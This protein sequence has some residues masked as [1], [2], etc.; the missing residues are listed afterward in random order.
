MVFACVTVTVAGPHA[1]P[2]SPDPDPEPE[3]EPEPEPE[4]GEPEAPDSPTPFVEDAA[5]TVEV[6]GRG[7]TLMVD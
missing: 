3:L 6:T 2:L 4:P 1:A 5:Y 7:T